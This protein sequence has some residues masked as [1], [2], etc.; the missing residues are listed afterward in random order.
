MTVSEIAHTDTMKEAGGRWLVEPFSDA[1]PDQLARLRSGLEEIGFSEE[2]ICK[3]AGISSIY[4]LAELPADNPLA[5]ATDALAIAIRLLIQS[6]SIPWPVVWSVFSPALI[7]AMSSVGLLV[8]TNP[9]RTDGADRAVAGAAMSQGDCLATVSLYPIGRILLAADRHSELFPVAEGIPADIVY[10]AMTEEAEQFVHLMPRTPC[11]DYLELCSGTGVAALTA[12]QQFAQHAWGVDVAARSTRFA[13]F[14]AALNNLDNT[15]MLTGDLYEPVAGHTFDVITAHPPYVPAL[16]TTMVY[17]DG[18]EDGEGITRRIVAG[19]PAHL[20]PGGLFYGRCM[21][22]DRKGRP[23]EV[24]LREMLG[25]A[26]TE[27]DVML[28]QGKVFDIVSHLDISVAAGRRAPEEAAALRQRFTDL[29][30]ERFVEVGFVLHRRL[31]PSQRAP[32]TIR[33][34]LSPLTTGH[35]LLWYLKWTEL[36]LQWRDDP[37]PLLDTRPRPANGAELRSRSLLRDGT[38]LVTHAALLSRVPFVAEG[39]CPAW[40]AT[41][42]GWCD[43]RVTAREHLARLREL[44]FISPSATDADFALIV[45]RLADGGLIELEICPLPHL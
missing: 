14:N 23:I 40:F 7:E 25:S 33:K 22:T 26:E 18:G 12:A 20:R 6:K 10:T 19:V 15:T 43:G 16:T 44:E 24:R 32:L 42:L 28:A 41:L 38:W 5:R 21:M 37:T 30:V 11:R 36:S 45:Q 8:T 31:D 34:A 39:E 13:A 17:R 1:S 27:F 35:H 4:E 2:N 29:E 9:T 3:R